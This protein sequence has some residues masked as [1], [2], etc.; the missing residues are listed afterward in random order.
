MLMF[1]DVLR[2]LLEAR[3]YGFSIFL[4]A[5]SLDPSYHFRKDGARIVLMMLGN[6]QAVSNWAVAHG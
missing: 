5:F 1:M 4:L 2:R 6:N 3:R